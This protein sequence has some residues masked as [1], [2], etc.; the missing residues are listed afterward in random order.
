MEITLKI[1]GMQCGHCSSRVKAAL[2]K[3]EGV[4]SAEVSHETGT[5]VITGE[6]LDAAALKAAVENQG[7]SVVD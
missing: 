2:E 6:S 1:E 7:F 4:S 3:V 5:A